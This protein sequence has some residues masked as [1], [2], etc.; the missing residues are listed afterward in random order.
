MNTLSRHLD[1]YLKLRRQLGFKL[2]LAG[3]MLRHF[4]RY[5]DQEKAAFVTVKLALRWATHPAGLTQ[6]RNATR[7]GYVRGFA[8]YLSAYDPRTEIPPV[9]LVPGQFCRRTPH[10]YQ[11]RDIVRLLEAT[12]HI[13]GSNEFKGMAY[14]TL[15]GLLAVTGLRIGEA[16]GL[17]RKDVELHRSLLIVRRAKGNKTRLVPLHPTTRQALER[18][19]AMRD[20]AF[21]EPQTTCFF[22]SERGTRLADCTVNNWFHQV[23]CQIGLRQPGPRRGPRVHDLRHYFAVRTLL[24]WY[25][26]DTD[27]EVHLPELS[28]YLGHTSVQQTY[29][30]LSAVPELLQLATRRWQQREGTR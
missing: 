29:W 26:S 30:Y 1:A 17:E 13:D 20:K 15:L 16:T 23:A 11:D 14:A 28:T 4:V 18:Y 3:H 9:G 8:R 10:L 22:V 6:T 27:V 21:P 7:L 25:R 12:R 5:A 24:R 2:D 19:V